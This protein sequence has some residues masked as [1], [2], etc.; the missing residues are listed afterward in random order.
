MRI[1]RKDEKSR[2]DLREVSEFV[3]SYGGIEYAR[4]RMREF[5]LDAREAVSTSPASDA[6]SAL[7]GLTAYTIQRSR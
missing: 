7:L 4:A 2:S 3:S 1:I 5:A 6:K